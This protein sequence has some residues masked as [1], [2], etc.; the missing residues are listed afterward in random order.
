MIP[1]EFISIKDIAGQL[2][3]E[4]WLQDLSFEQIA[5]DT[6]EL[7]RIVGCP[8]LF[9][10]KEADIE[11]HDWKALLPCDF[12]RIIQARHLSPDCKFFETYKETLDTFSLENSH[13][14]RDLQYKIKNRVFWSTRK[15]GIVH[16][17]YTALKTDEDGFPMIADNAQFIRA[18]KA[19]IKWNFAKQRFYE[20]PNNG[21]AAIKNDLEMEYNTYVAQAQNSLIA[22]DLGLMESLSAMMNSI[23][24]RPQDF[25]NNFRDSN[26]HHTY[27]IH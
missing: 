23:L 1:T 16:L 24:A 9:E 12:Y 5:N 20:D 21:N 4:Q 17:A 14:G 25:Y 26:K 7:I 18:L 22:P 8:A 19:Y 13:C 10:D 15:E 2:Y 3:S 6:L 27:R 11:L